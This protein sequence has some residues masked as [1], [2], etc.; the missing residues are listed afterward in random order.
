MAGPGA[1]RML[2]ARRPWE[3]WRRSEG[4]ARSARSTS[5]WSVSL[6]R[7][8]GVGVPAA[9]AA[10]A[11][12]AGAAGSFR[13][14]ECGQ[15]FAKWQGQCSACSA[16]GSVEAARVHTPMYRQANAEAFS[17][18]RKAAHGVSWANRSGDAFDGGDD[19][20]RALRMVDV[21]MDAVAKRLELPERELVPS[22]P[23]RGHQ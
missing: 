8:R 2:L 12:A 22:F 20:P 21:E 3:A 18:A 17:K 23:A 14:T 15:A 13:C 10:F 16:W 11:S 9:T 4:V 19:E 7:A 6:V 5:P 1:A